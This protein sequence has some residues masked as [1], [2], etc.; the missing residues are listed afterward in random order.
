VNLVYGLG[1]SDSYE[2]SYLMYR[3]LPLVLQQVLNH[4][5]GMIFTLEILIMLLL[6]RN[7]HQYKRWILGWVCFQ[8]ASLFVTG[9][10]SRTE[11]LVI[12]MAFGVSY[13]YW[14]RPIKMR[15]AL[16]VGT[17]GLLLFMSLGIVRGLRELNTDNGINPLGYANEFEIV[18]G[19]AYDISHIRTGGEAKDIFPQFYLSDFFN[20][21][22]QQF[23]PFKKIDLA[24]WYVNGFYPDFAEGGGGL[25]FGAI[26]ESMLG[27]GWV[28]AIWRGALVGV[29]FA[30]LYRRVLNGKQSIWS[31]GF[32]TWVLVFSYQCFRGTTFLL[33]PRAFYQFL[34][35]VVWAKIL[36]C[37][38]SIFQTDNN[39]RQ[40]VPQAVSG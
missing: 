31:V 40:I 28:D 7:F 23:L 14:V 12:L 18:L 22:P 13:H 32:Y 1:Q 3:G 8:I 16:I 38:L 6:V 11:L 35:V 24:Y 9:V 5:N 20:L 36:L 33:V 34:S 15:V 21:V 37:I 39:G 4:L 29:V 19:N 30:W 10:G 26:P 27:L 25:A 17:V 2:E